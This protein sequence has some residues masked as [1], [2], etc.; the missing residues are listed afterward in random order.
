MTLPPRIAADLLARESNPVTR[1]KIT[2]P[3]APFPL[4]AVAHDA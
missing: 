2:L 3:K 1:A 4:D